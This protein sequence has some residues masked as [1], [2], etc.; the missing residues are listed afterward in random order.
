MII[1]LTYTLNIE[2]MNIVLMIGKIQDYER[3]VKL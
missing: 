1:R 3:L 2:N